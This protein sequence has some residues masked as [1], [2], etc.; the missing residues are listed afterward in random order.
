MDVLFFRSLARAETSEASHAMLVPYTG[1]S[2]LELLGGAFQSPLHVRIPFSCT[3]FS[4]CLL[5]ER[6]AADGGGAAAAGSGQ[7]GGGSGGSSGGSGGSGGSGSSS[8]GSGGS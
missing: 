4:V 8:G 3:S 1:R 7:G 2:V 6:Q 5:D